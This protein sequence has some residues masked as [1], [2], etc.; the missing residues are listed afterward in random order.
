M[1]F[2]NDKNGSKNG[3]SKGTV[4]C[5]CGSQQWYP[6]PVPGERKGFPVLVCAQCGKEQPVSRTTYA[7]HRYLC[8]DRKVG[9]EFRELYDMT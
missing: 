2:A 5:T 7:L 3:L 6:R 4:Q 9:E 1:N 8:S